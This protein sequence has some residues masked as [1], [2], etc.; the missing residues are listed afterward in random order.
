MGQKG[1]DAK[2]L[3][4]TKSDQSLEDED[5]S[6]SVNADEMVAIRVLTNKEQALLQHLNLK[7]HT[8]GDRSDSI[9]SSISGLSLTDRE[10]YQNSFR[11][12]SL[13]KNEVNMIMQPIKESMSQDVHTEMS[14][15]SL[16]QVN[17]LG[18]SI[19]S[20]ESSS[21]A[22]LITSFSRKILGPTIHDLSPAR[23]YN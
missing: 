8:N 16:L 20:V 22:P 2:A 15:V 6:S 1:D 5:E 12:D 14:S 18:Q 3:V 7:F 23:R 21:T 11:S 19:P 17:V 9:I 4:Q 10:D 13:E